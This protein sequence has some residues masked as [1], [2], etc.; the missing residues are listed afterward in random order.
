MSSTNETS[1]LAGHYSEKLRPTRRRKKN[2]GLCLI[3]FLRLVQ[4]NYDYYVETC[5]CLESKR[6]KFR[7]GGGGGEG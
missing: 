3:G 2:G 7:K 5:V 4:F 6:S 1:D